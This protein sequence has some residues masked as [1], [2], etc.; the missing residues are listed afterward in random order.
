MNG[1]E[2]S[3][4]IESLKACDNEKG[5]RLQYREVKEKLSDTI[6]KLTENGESALDFLHPLLLKEGTWSCL[7]ALETLK[8]IKSEKSTP[9]LMEFIKKNENEDHLW[10]DCEEAMFALSAIGEPAIEPLLEEVNSAFESKIYYTYL[11][12]ALT[13][14]KDEKVYAFMKNIVEDFIGNYRKYKGWFNIECFVYEF[15]SQGNK[16]ILPLLKKMAS[17][18]ELTGHERTEVEDTI[19][20]VDDPEGFKKETEEQMKSLKPL[21]EAFVKKKKV[22]RNEPCPCGSGKKYKKCCLLKDVQ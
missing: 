18:E 11:V 7:F 2:I 9:F 21:A 17:M 15:E 4:L 12:G 13:R 14:I 19:R 16:E 5:Y 1:E 8:G 22:G 20:V 6:A 10:D 3:S